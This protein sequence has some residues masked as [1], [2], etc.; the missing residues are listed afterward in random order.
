MKAFSKALCLITVILA[1]MCQAVSCGGGGKPLETLTP[2][3]GSETGTDVITS[4]PEETTYRRVEDSLPVSLNLSG[5]KVRFL[6]PKVTA[7]TTVV[8]LYALELTSEPVND[9]VYNRELFV[10]ERLGVSIEFPKYSGSFLS[11]MQKQ[12]QSGDETFD[13]YCGIQ[14]EM[15][16]YCFDGYYLDLSEL[17]YLDFGQPWWNSDFINECSIR[18][19]VFM[20]TGSLS[21]DLLR[22]VFA[23]YYNKSMATDYSAVKEGLDD[24]Y[25]VVDS[26]KWT[27]DRMMEL[28]DGIYR[29][30]N[31]DQ[32]HDL[33]DVY[34]ILVIENAAAMPWGAFDLSAF[35]KDE[36]DWFVFNVNEEKLFD[37]CQK[38]YDLYYENPGSVTSYLSLSDN[39]ARTIFAGGNALFLIDRLSSVEK[40]EFR[41]MKDDYGILPQPKFDEGQ[42]EYCAYPDEFTCFSIPATNASPDAA[43]AVLEAMASYSYNETVPT[44]LDLALKGRYMSDAQSRKM[45]DLLVG[46]IK[47]EAAWTYLDEIGAH[48]APA[49]RRLIWDRKTSFAA[50]HQ[51]SVAAVKR[52]LTAYKIRYRSVFGDD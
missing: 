20:I 17:D 23:V 39:S 51:E 52:A 32:I 18:N 34:G 12:A 24:L 22:E 27:M 11:E 3:T 40:T 1:L 25:A 19:K 9:S 15:A 4:M 38:M 13:I 28:S 45:I 48:Y 37:A 7:Q 21:L 44:Y 16:D 36:D 35:E 43:A 8:D 26:G 6:A 10:E 30:L 42:K 31:G 50:Q 2:D 46:N 14:H 33:E 5:T 29:D 41:N 49:F 47:I